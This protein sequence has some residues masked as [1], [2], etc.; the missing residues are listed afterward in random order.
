M[1]EAVAYRLTAI[2]ADDVVVSV[3]I[4]S[5]ESLR[6]ATKLLMEEGYVVNTEDLAELPEGT[7]LDIEGSAFDAE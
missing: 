6:Y 2:N 1:D 4:V 5:P 7:V 3:Q